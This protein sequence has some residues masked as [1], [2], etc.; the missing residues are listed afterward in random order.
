MKTL[1][2][3]ENLEFVEIESFD[4]NLT[5]DHNF[6]TK[7]KNQYDFHT[8]KLGQTL[9][10][11]IYKNGYIIGL[12]FNKSNMSGQWIDTIME[13]NKP[14]YLPFKGNPF[15]IIK[16]INNNTNLQNMINKIFNLPEEVKSLI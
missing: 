12:G 5:I 13:N 6:C 7:L 16:P 4:D 3:D 10:R 15:D 11:I 8:T 1:Y 9:Y 2:K 14:T